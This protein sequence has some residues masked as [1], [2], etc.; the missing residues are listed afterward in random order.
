[1]ASEFK[2]KGKA[3]TVYHSVKRFSG[4]MPSLLE[5]FISFR[6]IKMKSERL[7]EFQGKSISRDEGSFL[8]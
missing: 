2:K 8:L 1:M 5:T 7:T 6:S 4:I 3:F